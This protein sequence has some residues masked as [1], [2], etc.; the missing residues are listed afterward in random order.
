MAIGQTTDAAEPGWLGKSGNASYRHFF[1]ALRVALS[2]GPV[3]G[4][5]A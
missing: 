1:P 4:I 3:W 5:G 2:L